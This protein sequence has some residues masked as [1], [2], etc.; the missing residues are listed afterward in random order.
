[1]LIKVIAEVLADDSVSVVVT[2]TNLKKQRSIL[3][4]VKVI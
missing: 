3:G 2:V 1:M 4:P